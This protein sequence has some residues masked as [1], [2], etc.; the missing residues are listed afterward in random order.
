MVTLSV[1]LPRPLPATNPTGSL[2]GPFVGYC[3]VVLVEAA[4]AER[5]RELAIASIDDGT[6]EDVGAREC[7]PKSL[8]ART[9]E[10]LAAAGPGA[11]RVAPMP[12][13]I[14]FTHGPWWRRVWR[15]L[16]GFLRGKP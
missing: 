7:D 2:K 10:L 8:P 11:E 5:A 14:F 16:A 15:R 4:T 1:R 13:R 12:G 9:A 3:K 6:A